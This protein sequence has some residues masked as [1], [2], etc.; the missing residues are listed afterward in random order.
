[1]LSEIA[2]GSVPSLAGRA[3]LRHDPLRGEELILLP[4]RVIRL[5]LTA[6]AIVRLCDGRRT[7]STI[8]REL[9]REYRREG[10][11]PAVLCLLRR[12]GEQGAITW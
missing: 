12:L 1:M 6:E 11:E 4:E 8:A 5:N 2:P 3:L 7:V 9:E 10:L